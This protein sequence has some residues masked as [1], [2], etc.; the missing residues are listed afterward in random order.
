MQLLSEQYT[1][2]VCTVVLKLL[3]EKP[4]NTVKCS[5]HVHF[6]KISVRIPFNYILLRSLPIINPT[7]LCNI[8]SDFTEGL[9]LLLP[10]HKFLRVNAHCCFKTSLSCC[11]RYSA[12]RIFEK[13]KKGDSFHFSDNLLTFFPTG[14]LPTFD[15][16]DT[17]MIPHIPERT[18]AIFGN[19]YF[20]NNYSI[21]HI[22]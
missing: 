19:C 16:R 14:I 18:K 2:I 22:F 4:P 13:R 3:W 12:E 9:L 8:I 10:N 15:E 20:I 1:L 21:L 11:I 5:L 17:T 7:G 6:T